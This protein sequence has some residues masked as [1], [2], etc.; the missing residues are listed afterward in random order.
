M[1]LELLSPAF[2][3]GAE[4][5]VL[6]PHMPLRPSTVRGLLRFWFRAAAGALIWPGDSSREAMDRALN[7]IRQVETA[8][9]G[10]T[11]RASTV[12]VLPPKGGKVKR[13]TPSE[14]DPAARPG[15]RYLGYGLFEDRHI[16][17]EALETS[18]GDTLSLTLRLRRDL[19]GAKELLGATVWLWTAIGGVGARSRRGFGSLGYVDGGKE[20]DWPDALCKRAESHGALATDN[21]GLLGCYPGFE[22][23]RL[24]EMPPTIKWPRRRRRSCSKRERKRASSAVAHS[25]H[26]RG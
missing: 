18:P 2:V 26:A 21:P 19:A 15:F 6:D 16:N 23:A 5:R 3:G 7:A 9:F 1:Q 24:D 11:T 25:A 4:P 17:P 14:I 13:F 8:L 22:F 10:D 20:W 12:V